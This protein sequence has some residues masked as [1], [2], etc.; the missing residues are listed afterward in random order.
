MIVILFLRNGGRKAKHPISTLCLWPATP[1]IWPCPTRKARL[2]MYVTSA[3]TL[4]FNPHLLYRHR[5]T[6][7][8]RQAT[9]KTS[10]WDALFSGTF[11]RPSIWI[12]IPQPEGITWKRYSS[13]EPCSPLFHRF[14]D[15]VHDGPSCQLLIW[16]RSNLC[17]VVSVIS[18]ILWKS[19][20]GELTETQTR[21]RWLLFATRL[22]WSPLLCLA[23]EAAL[24][25]REGAAMVLVAGH[26]FRIIFNYTAVLASAWISFS[27]GQECA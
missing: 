8:T 15:H 26:T 25:A 27:S 19:V 5:Q 24:E 7:R 2:A 13:T 10:H 14:T 21:K 18:H 17:Y 12:I 6:H 9:A 3:T 1:T 20:H 22:G 11:K 23:L 4:L 16:I